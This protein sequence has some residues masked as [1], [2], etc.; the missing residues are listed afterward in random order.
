MRE[1]R[2]L[3]AHQVVPA[4]LDG[5]DLMVATE[6]VEA[7]QVEAG[8]GVYIIGREGGA[9]AAVE[10]HQ[11]APVLL[12]IGALHLTEELLGFA[13][14]VIVLHTEKG[15]VVVALG[16]ELGDVTA[17]KHVAINEDRPTLEAHQ[18]GD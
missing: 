5:P 8:G 2:I 16:P 6:P 13:G 7:V 4:A 17:A 11:R 3:H 14:L 1:C 12:G 18:V 10:Q 15:E 9:A